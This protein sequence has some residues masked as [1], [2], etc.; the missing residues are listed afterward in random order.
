MDILVQAPVCN[1]EIKYK[2]FRRKREGSGL[3]KNSEADLERMQ[4]SKL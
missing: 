4:F 3:L 2:H 1:A